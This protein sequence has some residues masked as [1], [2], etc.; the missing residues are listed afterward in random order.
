M[1]FKISAPLRTLW[2]GVR[3]LHYPDAWSERHGESSP[4]TQLWYQRAASLTY[5]PAIAD[6]GTLSNFLR[7]QLPSSQVSSRKHSPLRP[8]PPTLLCARNRFPLCLQ[9][10]NIFWGCKSAFIDWECHNKH[11]INVIHHGHVDIQSVGSVQCK[12]FFCPNPRFCFL[13]S[14]GR[15]GYSSHLATI[16][17]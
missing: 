4:V 12:Q 10:K 14:R 9:K 1:E 16:N 3:I 6:T 15:L 17:T 13:S 7:R 2:E 5:L 8:F 11:V